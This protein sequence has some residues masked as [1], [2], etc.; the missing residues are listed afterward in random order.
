MMRQGTWRHSGRQ[1]TSIWYGY[2]TSMSHPLMSTRPELT[3]F[4]TGQSDKAKHC[5]CSS[6]I[7]IQM[8]FP[9]KNYPPYVPC[10]QA[11]NTNTLQCMHLN[12]SVCGPSQSARQSLRA[13]GTDHMPV[14]TVSTHMLCSSWKHQ[15]PIIKWWL[16]S[17]QEQMDIRIEDWTCGKR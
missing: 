9:N 12:S 14:V 17:S 4:H 7:E 1:T 10:H 3:L 11:T 2:V 8:V 16:G 6:W 15:E 13:A 5:W